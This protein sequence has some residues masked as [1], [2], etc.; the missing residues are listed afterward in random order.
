MSSFVGCFLTG[1][2]AEVTP[3]SVIDRF[4]FQVCQTIM[5]LSENIRN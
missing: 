2:A 5:D 3:V 1:T 4:N